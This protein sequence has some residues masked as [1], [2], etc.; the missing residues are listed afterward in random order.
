MANGYA[1]S[2]YIDTTGDFEF[3]IEFWPQKLLQLGSG[4]P[5]LTLII[6]IGIT[7][8]TKIDRSRH[9]SVL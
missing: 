1:N 7:V 6:L 4:I 8:K 3:T 5:M 2:W 9:L